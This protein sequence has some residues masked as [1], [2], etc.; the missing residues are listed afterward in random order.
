MTD[1]GQH[2]R[3]LLHSAADTTA[4]YSQAL[5]AAGFSKP[6]CYIEGLHAG[7][8]RRVAAGTHNDCPAAAAS[9]EK[10]SGADVICAHGCPFVDGVCPVSVEEWRQAVL[11]EQRSL[12]NNPEGR[13]DSTTS[14]S[15]INSP[16]A[17]AQREAERRK[18]Q[19][20]AVLLSLFTIAYSLGEG[21]SGLVLG[22][23]NVSVSL[24][25]LGADS[26]IEIVSSSLVCWRFY[27]DLRHGVGTVVTAQIATRKER[28]A[29]LTIGLL[30]CLLSAAVIAG[31]VAALVTRELPESDVPNIVIGTT[32]A[33]LFTLVWLLKT[34]VAVAL[35]SSTVAADAACSLCCVC[36]N[37][38][39]LVGAVVSK[40]AP[41]VW[42]F[43]SATAIVL[44]L[45]IGREG[46][47]TVA[48]SA[49]KDFTGGGCGCKGEQDGVVMRWMRRW[50]NA[51]RPREEAPCSSV[52]VCE[53]SRDAS[54]CGEQGARSVEKCGDGKKT[55][56]TEEQPTRDERSSGCAAAAPVCPSGQD[57]F[58]CAAQSS[59]SGDRRATEKSAASCRRKRSD[60]GKDG[61]CVTGAC[62]SA[63]L[64]AAS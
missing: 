35:S 10:E 51:G 50:A 11:A 9:D 52:A 26:W 39:L 30:F 8:E 25:A 56:C 23:K 7:S 19:Q 54:C 60:C 57:E 44:A 12:K 18:W 62:H 36:L 55:C 53:S 28:L 64:P 46:Y 31:S 48:A 45:V 4:A 13:T 49:K 58:C 32:G 16:T 59:C 37:V 43:D 29:T 3:W 27:S 33:A 38:V 15:P 47:H 1:S 20:R 6:P 63:G 41:S 24:I 17:E 61:G 21:V 2:P 42:W 5:I 40:E 14:P 34:R 22:A